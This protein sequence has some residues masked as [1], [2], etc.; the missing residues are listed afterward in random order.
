MR[1]KLAVM[2]KAAEALLDQDGMVAGGDGDVQ[3]ADA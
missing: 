2:K 3:M 1:E